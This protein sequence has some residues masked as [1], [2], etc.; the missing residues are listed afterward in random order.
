MI[1]RFSANV[2]LL[3]GLCLF[4]SLTLKFL[5]FQEY[6]AAIGDIAITTERTKMVDF[7]QP[8]IDSGLVVV[9]PVK[10]W[11]SNAWAFL[12]PFTPTMWC[13]TGI[14]FLVVGTVVW[15]LEHRRNDEFRGPPRKQ[16]ITIL[17]SVS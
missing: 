12:R 15:I 7:T 3:S 14:F 8:F 5:S 16:F 6:D 17:W 2:K 9:A 13:I 11:S 1:S 4:K 10:E